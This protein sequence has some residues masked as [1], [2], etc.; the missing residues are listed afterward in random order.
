M[1]LR[2]YQRRAVDRTSDAIA[3]RGNSLLIAATGAGKTLM[4]SAITANFLPDKD[5]RAAI[6]QHRDELVQQNRTKFKLVNPAISTGVVNA[7]EKNW[8]RQVTFAMIDTVRSERNL[9]DLPAL[10]FIAVDECH[11]IMAPGYLRMIERARQLN[12]NVRLLGVTAT[13]ERTDN[14]ALRECFDNVGDEITLVELIRSGHLV[15]PRAFV[16]DIGTQAA[17]SALKN[18][19][20]YADQTEVAK[21]QDKQPHN[22]AV[23]RHWK[24]KA[25]DRKTVFYTPSVEAAKHLTEEFVR[26]GVNAAYVSGNTDSEERRRIIQKFDQSD[27]QVL[28]NCMVLTEGFDSQPVSCVGITRQCSSK[29]TLIQMIGRG[30][31]TV[32]AEKYP[33]VAK[34]D[35]LIL[36]F[37]ISLLTHKSL[38]QEFDLDARRYKGNAAPQKECPGCAASVPMASMT[39]RLCGYQ[40]LVK[41]D[42]LAAL[43]SGDRELLADFAM[44][45]VELLEESPYRWEEIFDGLVMVATAFDAWAMCVYFKHEWHALGGSKETGIR[46]LAN[47]ERLIC[48]AAADDYLRQY[49]DSKAAKKSKQWLKLAASEAQLRHLGLPIEDSFRYTRYQAACLLTWKFNERGIQRRLTDPADHALRQAV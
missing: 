12:P 42:A 35:C 46:R 45:E 6:F 23:V 33:G 25:G 18:L 16:I 29:S 43:A 36:D 24:E 4:L 31:R 49:G 32:D 48:I 2:P 10:D 38:D 7:D 20:D 13:P 37:G 14:K 11:H 30:L 26:Q 17:L 3:N 40:F 15:K 28:I 34:R 1:I 27:L 44:T 41:D 9:A 39:C 47:G 8:S 22:E 19:S 5:A 21:I